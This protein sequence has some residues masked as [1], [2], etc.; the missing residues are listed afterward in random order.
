[1]QGLEHNSRKSQGLESKM[2]GLLWIGFENVD[3]V[4]ICRKFRAWA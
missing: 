1:M 3:L 4:V 2:K